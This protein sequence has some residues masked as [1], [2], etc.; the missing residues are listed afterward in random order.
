MF[1][2]IVFICDMKETGRSIVFIP[3]YPIPTSGLERVSSQRIFRHRMSVLT[4]LR[5]TFFVK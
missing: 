2:L 4:N 3:F 5:I 1:N